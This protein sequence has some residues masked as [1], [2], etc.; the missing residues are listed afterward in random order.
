MLKQKLTKFIWLRIITSRG[1]TEA[2][3]T[4]F[5][6]VATKTRLDERG[7]IHW[8]LKRGYE[9]STRPKV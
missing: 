5:I 6:S 2:S 7:S 4:S 8:I 1:T 3:G 9:D